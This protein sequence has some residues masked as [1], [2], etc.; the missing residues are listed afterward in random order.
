MIVLDA[1]DDCPAEEGPALLSRT[2]AVAPDLMIAV[3]FAKREF[4][5][6]FIASVESLRGKRGVRR[7]V[8]PPPDPEAI[9]GAKEWLS[10]HMTSGVSYRATLDQPALT[11]QFDVEAA[12]RARSFDHCYRRIRD[13]LAD[14]V[15]LAPMAPV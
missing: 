8:M 10:Q 11:A 15:P 1:D 3:I 5:A 2:R 4:E 9:R 13:L 6:W 7:D 14:P 12:R